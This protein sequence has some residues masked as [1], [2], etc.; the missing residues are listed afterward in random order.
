MSTLTRELLPP[1]KTNGA[2][3]TGVLDLITKKIDVH[4]SVK[5][6]P[7]MAQELLT[8]NTGN[9]PVIKRTLMKYI[10]DMKE[11]KWTFSGNT[12]KFDNERVL[13]D[14]QHSLLAVVDTGTSQIFNIQTG[15]SPESF[16]V[17]DTGRGRSAGDVL[18]INGYTNYNAY[19]AAIKSIL[20]YQ[21]F[22]RLRSNLQGNSVSN[23]QVEEFTHRSDMR[24][25]RQGM[26]FAEEMKQEKKGAFLALSTWAFIYFI[27]AK[28]SKEDAAEFLKLLAYG[29][30]ISMTR[31]H[32]IYL[33]RER[34][35][36]FKD[37]HGKDFYAARGSQIVEMKF[38]YILRAWNAW[39]N[40]EKLQKLKVDAKEEL[41]EKPI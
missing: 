11:G 14:G 25:L 5:I 9:R 8:L 21:Q 4:S 23:S 18:A 41:L 40:K 27:L 33:C 3:S 17:M 24:L 32:Q 22:Q 34:L 37:V 7:A 30:N 15:L 2:K 31:H 1:T 28:V 36:S 20:Y 26:E 19:G 13:R 39:R 12:I 10:H 29:E 35:I 16:A 38:R 6:T